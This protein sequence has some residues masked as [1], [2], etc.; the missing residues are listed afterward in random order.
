MQSETLSFYYKRHEYHAI[1]RIKISAGRTLYY[2]T[3]MNSQLERQFYG[4]HI[5]CQEDGEMHCVFPSHSSPVTDIVNC[6]TAAL[7]EEIQLLTATLST[8]AD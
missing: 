6:V 2:I 1:V 7:Q 4:H 8:P 5:F 3:I